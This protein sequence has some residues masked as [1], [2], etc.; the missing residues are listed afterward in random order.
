M[1]ELAKKYG[2]IWTLSY[3]L[4]Y[5]VWFV[6]LEQRQVEYNVVFME[7]DNIIPFCEY[8]IIP[9]LLW[10]LYVPAVF[11]FL[12]FKSKSEYYKLCQIL[13]SGM[14]IF[15]IIC[16]LWPNGQELRVNLS[17][18]NNVFAQIVRYLYSTDTSTNVFPSIHVFN[19]IGV[20]IALVK[21]QHVPN[22]H[23]V[24][25]ASAILM[26]LICMA[27]VFL[28]QHSMLDV[29]GGVTMA[30]ILYVWVYA[31]DS[32]AISRNKKERVPVK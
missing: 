21:S 22:N 15:L 6:W 28:K 25:Y 4:L 23:W 18:H 1:K 3:L 9:Y 32:V 11:V 24:R 26:V 12:F 19:S 20:H 17:G 30:V 2:H 16:T 29:I 31:K 7:I 5:M 27:T 13:F 8:F 10:F 14:T